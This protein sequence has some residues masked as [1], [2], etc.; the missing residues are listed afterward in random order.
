MS[1]TVALLEESSAGLAEQ[2]FL[3]WKRSLHLCGAAPST[4]CSVLDD[5]NASGVDAAAS[6]L[7]FSSA[8]EIKMPLIV[9]WPFLIG[10][11]YMHG[12]CHYRHPG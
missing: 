9:P 1:E 5:S 8:T 7:P 4:D 6:F 3:A 10:Y 12:H 11:I 2:E